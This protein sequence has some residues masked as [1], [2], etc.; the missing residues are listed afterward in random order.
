MKIVEDIV[1]VARLWSLFNDW[2]HARQRFATSGI[3]G[4]SVVCV[5]FSSMP[6]VTSVMNSDEPP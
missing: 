1:S 6:V 5:T 2:L 3:F 4:Y